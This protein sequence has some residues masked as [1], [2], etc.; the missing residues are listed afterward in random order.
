[1]KTFIVLQ[2]IVAFRVNW[3]TLFNPHDYRL[4]LIVHEPTLSKLVEDQKNCFDE[5]HTLAHFNIEMLQFTIQNILQIN[6]TEVSIITNDELCIAL[7]AKLREVFNIQGDRVA[8]VN[9]FLNK[10]ENKKLVATQ[11]ITLP[12]Y[13][14]FNPVQFKKEPESYNKQL[15][16]KLELPIFAKPIDSVASQNTT[17]INT[18]DELLRWEQ[19]HN[20]D[21]NYELDE[22]ISGKL[23]HVDSIIN[24]NKIIFAQV[25]EN[26]YPC[27][28]FSLGKINASIIVPSDGPLYNQLIQFNE[29]ALMALR[30]LPNCVTHLEIFQRPNG[31]LVY[32]EVACRAPGGAIVQM[33]EKHCGIN[34]EQA[35]FVMQMGLEFN[36]QHFQK[37]PYCAWAWFPLAEGKILGFRSLDIKSPHQIAWKV[38]VG[39]IYQKAKSLIDFAGSIILWNDDYEILRR[40][41]DYLAQLNEPP[42]ITQVAK[43]ANL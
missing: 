17:K 13:E 32:L 11:N 5:I 40:D 16:Q 33:H 30:P 14:R 9:K 41:F 3:H 22:F 26:A 34:F 35:H 18:R 43:S 20:N 29:Q 12:K 2:K 27:F 19:E 28:D 4:I 23:Y 1:M 6:S 24:N 7:A 39:E 25:G 36:M 37:G 21:F 10:E 42:V 38:K 31:E 8:M 15:I